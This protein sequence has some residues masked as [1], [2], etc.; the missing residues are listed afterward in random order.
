MILGHLRLTLRTVVFGGENL[1][2]VGVSVSLKCRGSGREVVATV[3]LR[4]G[5][6]GPPFLPVRAG[7]GQHWC[8]GAE[9]RQCRPPSCRTGP[10]AAGRRVGMHL[11]PINGEREGAA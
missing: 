1:F 8:L 3:M 9:P 11:F 5:T 6:S 2:T 4:Q 10:A 7:P